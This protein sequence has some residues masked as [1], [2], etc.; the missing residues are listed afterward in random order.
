MVGSVSGASF[1]WTADDQ[2]CSGPKKG[3]S[4]SST[5]EAKP[6]LPRPL[7]EGPSFGL[8]SPG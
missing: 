5:L 7:G 1:P 4:Q 6:S 2:A 3:R 8:P